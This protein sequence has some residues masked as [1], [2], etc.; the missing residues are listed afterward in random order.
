MLTQNTN[1]DPR[2]QGPR[3][4]IPAGPQRHPGQERKLEPHPDY[5][6]DS[7]HGHGRSRDRVALITGGDSGVGYA[8][9]P[10]FKG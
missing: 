3:P 4:P 9:A 7:Y 10:S 5:G 8:V 6:L 2:D 1:K